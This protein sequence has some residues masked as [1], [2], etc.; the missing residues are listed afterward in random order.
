MIAYSYELCYMS[1]KKL[2]FYKKIFLMNP[3]VVKDLFIQFSRY[4]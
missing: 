3:K 4:L 2:N 1:S